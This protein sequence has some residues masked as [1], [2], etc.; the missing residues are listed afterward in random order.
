MK[1]TMTAA[2]VLLTCALPALAQELDIEVV[3]ELF[4]SEFDSGGGMGASFGVRPSVKIGTIAFSPDGKNLVVGSDK[5]FGIYALEADSLVERKKLT[6]SGMVSFTFSRDGTYLAVGQR[7]V[8]ELFDRSEGQYAQIQT[9][10]GRTAACFSKDNA[11]L[12]SVYGESGLYVHELFEGRFWEWGGHQTGHGKSIR[13]V[14]ASP[15]GMRLATA[16]DDKT[17]KIWSFS[18][19]VFQEAQKLGG[20]SRGIASAAWGADGRTLVTY[21]KDQTLVWQKVSDVY[22]QSQKLKASAES[23]NRLAMS[24][25]GEYAAVASGKEVKIFR[26][27]NGTSS[28]IAKVK[29]DESSSS[30]KVLSVAFSPDGRYLVAGYYDEVDEKGTDRPVVVLWRLR[31]E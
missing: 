23:R 2:L 6:N 7:D 8:V 24:A 29:P 10:R 5:E 12:I 20:H 30:A 19:G 17:V 14:R 4:V 16:S 9:L 1:R 13:D 31:E 21:D 18:S 27:P 15:D 11:Y 25:D 28:E 3:D 22:S 26:I